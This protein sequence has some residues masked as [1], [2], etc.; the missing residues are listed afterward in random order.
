V[1]VNSE[2]K[3]RAVVLA[4]INWKRTIKEVEIG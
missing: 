2:E 4:K 3:S 1:S